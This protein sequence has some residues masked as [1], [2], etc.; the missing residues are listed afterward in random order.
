MF[1]PPWV[2]SHGTTSSTPGAPALGLLV[3]EEGTRIVIPVRG[4]YYWSRGAKSNA[5]APGVVCQSAL[6]G[7]PL[8]FSNTPPT[9]P[10]SLTLRRLR[11][12]A[13][14]PALAHARNRLPQASATNTFET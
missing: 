11:R 5:P 13:I 3:C 12:L 8:A 1:T 6:G 4:R 10:M 7:Y 2:W 14:L 9:Y